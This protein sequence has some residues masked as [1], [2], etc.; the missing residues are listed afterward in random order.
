MKTAKRI[1]LMPSISR[2]VRRVRWI[3]AWISLE[4]YAGRLEASC[5]RM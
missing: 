1:M 5:V 2:W 3:R 4:R